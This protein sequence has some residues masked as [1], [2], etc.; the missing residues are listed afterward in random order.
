MHLF[1][2]PCPWPAFLAAAVLVLA[3]CP[4]TGRA[5]VFLASQPHPDFAIG[6]LFVTVAVRPD[7]GPVTVTLSWS[8]TPPPH[9]LAA[10]IKQ[11]LYLLWPAELVEATAP[12]PPDPEL[13]AYVEQR[14][15][16]ISGRGRL[17]LGSRDRLQVGIGTPATPLPEVASYVTFVRRTGPQVG[18]GT[19]I[20]IPWTPALADPLAV[21]V[22]AMTY[23]GLVTP[24]PATWF[25]EAFWGRRWVLS[26]GF[27][28]VGALVLP[29]YPLYFEHRDRFVP[30]ARE[31]SLVIATFADADHLRIEAIEP[32]GATRRPSRVRAGSEIVSMT[33]QPTQGISPQLLKV[34]FS[35]HA[36]VI[37]W[38]P[39]LVS[40]LLLLLGNLA[41]LIILS[42]NI[43]WFVRT[44]L[45]LRRPGEPEFTRAAGDLLPRDLADR[46]VP[47]V[48]TEAEALALCGHP[49]EERHRRAPEVRR[50][51]VYRG[52][53]RLAR[54]RLTLGR[55]ATVA[56]WEEEQ[57]EL[58]IDLDGDRVSSVQSRVRRQRL[59]L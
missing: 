59:V 55:L 20:K 28:D 6:P 45:H 5:Q 56:H 46:I 35:Y 43:K 21:T 39:V 32:P 48:T 27:G 57:H 50:T 47:G 26:T 22:L 10:G 4:A 31:F 52:A 23:R 33:L 1:S 13:I 24:K 38:R 53:R 34:Q 41:G 3:C 54:P 7:S 17:A 19:Y 9:G 25:E 18:P 36:G 30:L 29:L 51:L 15:F 16:A 11:G 8:L 42:Q 44:K 12:G 2:A 40:A 37:A 14:G 49:D 58:E